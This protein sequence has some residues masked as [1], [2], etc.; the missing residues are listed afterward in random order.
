MSGLFIDVLN[1]YVFPF[2]CY[3][4]C[5]LIRA[6]EQQPWGCGPVFAHR[7]GGDVPASLPVPVISVSLPPFFSRPRRPRSLSS[8][9]PEHPPY[10][11]GRSGRKDSS[12]VRVRD[13]G[14]FVVVLH[15]DVSYVVFQPLLVFWLFPAPNR[16][17]GGAYFYG[18][19]NI[20]SPSG[21]SFYNST[22]PADHILK[23]VSALLRQ[24]VAS[25]KPLFWL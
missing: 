6:K 2:D 13:V 10:P 7:I 9:S 3:T 17:K 18:L 23:N 20:C 15:G 8:V 12:P 22:D 16:V 25:Q 24:I 1:L 11:A 14:L 21:G 4:P 19:K 5:T